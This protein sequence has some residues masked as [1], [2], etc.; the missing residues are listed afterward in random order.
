MPL[1]ECDYHWMWMLEHTLSVYEHLWASIEC[2]GMCLNA[3]WVHVDAFDRALNLVECTW[4]HMNIFEWVWRQLNALRYWFL[5][6]SDFTWSTLSECEFNWMR[7]NALGVHMNAFEQVFNV[8]EHAW[9]RSEWNAIEQILNAAKC[10]WTCLS[11]HEC[12]W[13]SIEPM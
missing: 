7:L 13:V 4:V 9:M 6:K 8:L 5:Y 10:V 2:A 3:L 1:S 12:H 11:V